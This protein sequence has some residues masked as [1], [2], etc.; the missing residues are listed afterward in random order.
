[1]H[2]TFKKNSHNNTKYNLE[3]TSMLIILPINKMMLFSKLLLDKAHPQSKV[4]CHHSGV[5]SFTQNN[6]EECQNS[7]IYF[8]ITTQVK[9]PYNSS[10]PEGM[11]RLF[12]AKYHLVQVRNAE[13]PHCKNKKQFV[14]HHFKYCSPLPTI[15]HCRNSF[16]CLVS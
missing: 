6:L 12:P 8:S 14:S 5:F 2:C 10:S 3:H 4:K 9:Q 1:M 13:T 7:M 16:K 15:H 11:L